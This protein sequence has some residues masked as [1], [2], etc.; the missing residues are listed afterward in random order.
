[1]SRS[2]GFAIL[3]GALI[4][5]D[6]VSCRAGSGSW[7]PDW[8]VT[9]AATSDYVFRGV[10]LRN[11]RPSP[12]LGLDASYGPLYF[13]GVAIGVDLGTDGL[14]RRLGTTELDATFAMRAALGLVELS[15]GAK[16]TGYPT[17]RDLVAGTLVRAER[18]F[19][20]PFFGLETTVLEKLQIGGSVYWTPDFYNETG[21]VLTTEGRL[22]VVMPALGPLLW[23]AVATAGEV[24]SERSGAI[25][26]AKR[27]RY[28]GAGVEGRV[29]QFLIAIKYWDTD[30]DGVD[31]FDRR[32]AVSVGVELK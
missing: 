12:F 3:L 7:A 1:M 21:Q 30:V 9:V 6:P 28:F 23:K 11:G 18:D 8:N 17:G 4:L 32:V 14:D 27:Y 2:W 19:W 25:A 20:E 16:Y 15:G 10:S 13:S 29:D 5:I 26:P 22:S 24:T 31:I